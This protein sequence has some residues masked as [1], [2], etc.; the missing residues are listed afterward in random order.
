MLDPWRRGLPTVHHVALIL[1]VA[2]VAVTIDLA[3]VPGPPAAAAGEDG[4]TPAMVRPEEGEVWRLYLAVLGRRPE[5][6]GFGYWVGERVEGVPLRVVADSFLASR[7]F[8]ARFGSTTDHQFIELVY[9]HVLGRSG[10]PDGVA[11]WRSVVAGGHPR[12]EIV[13]LF[14][15]SE[16]HRAATDTALEPLPP[17]Q[18]DVRA[19][20]DSELGET[21][22]PGCPIDRSELRTVELDHVD[23]AGEH[24]RGTLV[25]HHDVGADVVD[26]FAELYAARFPIVM[27]V[28]VAHFDG[29][30]D[31]SMAAGNTSAFNCRTITG[32]TAWSHHA[33]GRAV[34]I[35]PIQNPYVNA[36]VVLPPA[37]VDHVD[38]SQYHPAMIRP[39][40]VV[41][42][43]FAEAG[44]RWGGEFT[45]IA[46]F[47]HFE[48]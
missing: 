37:G 2:I 17:F 38:R 21:W 33:F 42:D 45:R 47:Q 9:R 36:R 10:D 31:A 5:P 27:M 46:D 6:G 34:D 19:P 14:A 23:L 1:A 25:V 40:D 32:G 11:Y 15:E 30:D 26:V 41:T 18:P 7:E 12:A 48:R 35:N 39:G 44:W 43:A 20:T 22:R 13:L 4:P 8:D 16:E 29:D 3:T 24:R 28:P